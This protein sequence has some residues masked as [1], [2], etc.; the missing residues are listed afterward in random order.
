MLYFVPL[1]EE[2]TVSSSAWARVQKRVQK[3]KL[4]AHSTAMEA[5]Q[6]EHHSEP[7]DEEEHLP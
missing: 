4:V 1:Q 5:I 7:I 2:S 6:A 3:T